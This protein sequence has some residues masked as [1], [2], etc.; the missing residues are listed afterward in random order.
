MIACLPSPQ[1]KTVGGVW[2]TENLYPGLKTNNTYGTID[3]SDFPMHHGFGIK[4]GQHV[5][6]EAMHNYLQAY[7][8]RSNILPRIDF[9]TRVLAISRLDDRAGWNLRVRQGADERDLQTRKLIIATGVTNA[10]NRPSIEGASDF[11]AP[12]LHS[13]ELGLKSGLLTKDLSEKKTV[14]VLGGG[15]S[16]YDA[17]YLAACTGHQVEWIIRKSGKGPV[18]VPP[19]HTNIGPFKVLREVSSTCHHPLHVPH[20]AD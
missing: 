9:E 14:A 8:Q 13:A 12:I 4:P 10:P 18:W 11:E 19:R 6:G 2:A 20:N 3:F 15:K 1:N 16:A 17:V 7:A 5:S